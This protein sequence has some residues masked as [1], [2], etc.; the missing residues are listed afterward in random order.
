[1]NLLKKPQERQNQSIIDSFLQTKI[2]IEFRKLL[3]LP[4]VLK[5]CSFHMGNDTK[6]D[7]DSEPIHPFPRFPMNSLHVGREAP[8]PSRPQTRLDF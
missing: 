3:S 5:L 8:L 4:S 6:G 2:G 1:M 7:W